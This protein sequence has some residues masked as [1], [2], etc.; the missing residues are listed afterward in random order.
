[1]IPGW[2]D[3][4]GGGHG[5]PLQYSGLENPVDG[6]AWRATVHGVTKSWT[7][8]SDFTFTYPCGEGL[9]AFFV[10]SP[11][12]RHRHVEPGTRVCTSVLQVR[13]PVWSC[14]SPQH[15]PWSLLR[16]GHSTCVWM[17]GG[18]WVPREAGS[19]RN[20][21]QKCLNWV[22]GCRC[23][24]VNSGWPGASSSSWSECFW[25]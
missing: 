8:L 25:G 10:A 11:C 21:T 12:L 7:R 19:N 18:S 15:A 22:C 14:L 6:G 20:L 2:E 9:C 16:A 5:N 4:P 24:G 23:W 3:P 13:H 17:G 1:M